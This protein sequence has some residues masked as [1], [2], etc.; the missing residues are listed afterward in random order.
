VRWFGITVAA[1]A[2]TAILEI[3]LIAVAINYLGVLPTLLLMIATSALGV[4]LITRQSSRA[5]REVRAATTEDRPPTA[6]AVDGVYALVASLLVVVPGFLTDVVGLIALLPPVR[7]AVHKRLLAR[8]ALRLPPSMVGP[9]R[10]HAKR[11]K[12]STAG[13]PTQTTPVDARQLDMGTIVEGDV[14]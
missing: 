2:G 8:L 10:V 6:E 1:L 14:R 12:A 11:G 7:R 5:W 9:M 4:W 13:A 3:V